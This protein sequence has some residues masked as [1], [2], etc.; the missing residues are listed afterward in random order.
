VVDGTE[1]FDHFRDHFETAEL[2]RNEDVSSVGPNERVAWAA[3]ILMPRGEEPARR[4]GSTARSGDRE[5][6]ETRKLGFDSGGAVRSLHS[7]RITSLGANNEKTRTTPD[8]LV[9]SRS[10]K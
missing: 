4:R 10:T 8:L 6:C 5:P 1:G 9:K 2:P 7:H 3:T